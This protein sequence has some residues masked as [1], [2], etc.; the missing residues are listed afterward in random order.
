MASRSEKKK[1]TWID[2]WAKWYTDNARMRMRRSEKHYNNK[3]MRRYNKRICK[4]EE[5]KNK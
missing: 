4:E 3:F 5:D 2:S 1:F